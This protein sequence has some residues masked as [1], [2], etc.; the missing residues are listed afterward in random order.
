VNVFR[1]LVAAVFLLIV[2]G[3]SGTA[4]TATLTPLWQFNGGTDGGQP[5]AELV[6]GSDSNFYGMTLG[7][8][9]NDAGVVFKITPSG[10]FTDLHIFGG[11]NVPAVAVFSN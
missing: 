4:N 7:G 10:I 9:T 11:S 5:L 2:A 6:Q 1:A 3:R 8:G